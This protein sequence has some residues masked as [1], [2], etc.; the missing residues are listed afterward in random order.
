MRMEEGGEGG[1]V[2][3]GEGE[4]GVVV[5]GESDGGEMTEEMGIIHSNRVTHSPSFPTHPPSSLPPSLP[6]FLFPTHR[7]PS[8]PL[9]LAAAGSVESNRQ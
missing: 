2:E 7:P 3:E 1:G 9:T 8:L 6:P 4:G 5:E